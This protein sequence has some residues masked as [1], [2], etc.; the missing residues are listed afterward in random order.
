MLTY[1]YVAVDA[2]HDVDLAAVVR[3]GERPDLAA[4]ADDARAAAA[5]AGD[6]EEDAVAE[7]AV[8]ETTGVQAC[9]P[10]LIYAL[11]FRYY[12]LPFPEESSHCE[13]IR[14]CSFAQYAS[15]QVYGG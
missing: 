15:W 4:G 6:G 7:F 11:Y 1:P 13:L 3:G 9:R 10:V 14:A 8:L 2:Q 12:E 5:R